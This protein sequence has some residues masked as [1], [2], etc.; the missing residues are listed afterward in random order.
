MEFKE[1][2]GFRV[3]AVGVPFQEKKHKICT[4][5]E[6]RRA[7]ISVQGLADSGL[8]G[9]LL[10]G[11]RAKEGHES[12]ESLKPS[13]KPYTGALIITIGLKPAFRPRSV[14]WVLGC[15]GVGGFRW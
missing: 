9:S 4:S 14:D 12:R 2:F 10:Q 5:L 6:V 7:G 13:Q 8:R 3:C 1:V 11:F 15:W